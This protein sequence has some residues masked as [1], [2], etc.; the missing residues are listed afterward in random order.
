MD[1]IVIIALRGIGLG[2]VLAFI[3]LGFNVTFNS[4]GVLNFA[5]GGW[6]TLAGIGGFLLLPADPSFPEWMMVGLLVTAATAFLVVIQG[7]FTLLPL[8][9]S[10]DQHS[11]LVST[12]A[13][14]VVLSAAI[15][16]ILGPNL[17]R[18]PTPF[19][20][21]EIA[22]ARVPGAYVVIV[23]LLAL[24][25][26]GLSLFHKYTTTGL[27]M[28]AIAQDL[29][30]AKA[31]GLRVRRLQLVAFA[32][33]G[34]LAA[35]IGFAAGPVLNISAY[36]V[37]PLL[38]DGF[39]AA[40]VGGL[41]NNVGSVAGGISVGLFTIFVSTYFGGEAHAIITVLVL[42]LVLWLR[43]R[44]IFGRPAMRRV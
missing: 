27:A 3:A 2:A 41:G 40:V 8:E 19:G 34:A 4:S 11:W 37:F 44:G 6:V 39:L 43:P 17:M 31:A 12:L 9:S 24:W 30:A 16:I 15:L 18:V 1:D 38:V 13:I 7:Y 35:T 22:G 42:A 23:V 21:A 26:I 29:G 10:T 33:S 32:I 28:R 5:F 20:V 14:S 25:M 36:G